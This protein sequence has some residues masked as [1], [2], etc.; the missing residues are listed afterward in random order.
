MIDPLPGSAPHPPPLA[1][2]LAHAVAGRGPGFVP[3]TR[4]RQGNRPRYTNRLALE[5]SPYLL[6][7]AH[8][9]VDWRP[10]G[11]EAFADARQSGRPVF[12]S[13]GYSTCH[14]CHVMEE[15][16]FE[17][18]EIAA[19]LNHHFV[20]V[21]VDR[22][23]RPDVDAVYMTAVQ[24]LSGGGGWPMSVWLNADREPFFGGTYFP[25]RD[26]DRGAPVGFLS[27]LRQIDALWRTDPLRISK[28]AGALAGAVRIAL[29]GA[30]GQAEGIPGPTAVDA[31]VRGYVQRFDDDHGGLAGAPKFPSSLPVRLLL[32]HHRRTGDAASLHMATLSLTRMAAG[33]IHDQLAGGFHRYSTDSRWLVPHFEKMLYD[34]A[35]LAVAYAEAYQVTGR[36]DFARVVRSTLD[37]MLREMALPEG[38]LCSATDADSEG[39]E[40]RF[41][42]WSAREVEERLGE[43][44]A[45]FA[46]FHGVTAEGNFEGHNVLHVPR[47][48]EAEWQA[49]APARE[50]LRLLREGRPHPLRDDKVLAAWNGLALS[51]LAFG[52][53][54]LG[55]PR[56]VEAARRG[57]AFLLSTLRPGGRLR[58]SWNAGRLG[59]AAFLEDHAFL[60]RGLLDLHEATLEP[61]WLSEAL[62]LAGEQERLFADPAGG[63]FSTPAD[64]EALIARQK[65]THDG[66]EPCGASVAV[67]SALRLAALTGDDRWRQVA[68]GAL[69]AHGA[70]LA[71]HPMALAEMLLA[72][73]LRH[74]HPR[75]LVLVW[76]GG[77]P[78]EA[79]LGPLRTTFLPDAVLTGASEGAPLAE[80]ARLAP[81]A[82]GKVAAGGKPTAYVCRQGACGLPATDA[83]G[84]LRQLDEP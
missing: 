14:W 56:H 63:W 34:N 10:W 41:F 83:A 33:G 53:R 52:G 57:A 79:L 4:H 78:P 19:F 17:D 59:P 80:L 37:W 49:L 1:E 21:K 25:P 24:A 11:D 15:E 28:A 66:A 44:A 8:N 45:R 7:H 47:P 5:S 9:P 76:P 64:G 75:E 58:R 31:A 18:P 3:R 51:A 38:G 36:P 22:E 82:E 70:S 69:R 27:A 6:Q 74:A 73:E 67:H 39:E 55:E 40:G 32:R 30:A 16:S 60:C 71:E 46:A 81:I 13:V 23:E 20:P 48:D 62:A 12:L 84:L 65:P 29:G 42:V 61:R 43:E 77:D 54:V 72:V 26:G 2:A 35:L 68:D 50:K